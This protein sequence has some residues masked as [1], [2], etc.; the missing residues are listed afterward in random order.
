[1]TVLGMPAPAGSTA[2]GVCPP[3][4]L[5]RQMPTDTELAD[6]GGVEKGC[7]RAVRGSAASGYGASKPQTIVMFRS[8]M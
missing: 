4:H 6:A 3:R 2:D 8:W 5:A 1:M 7:Q